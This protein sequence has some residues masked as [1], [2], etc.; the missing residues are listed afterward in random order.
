[1]LAV[2]I[3][4][5]KLTFFEATLQSLANQ[6]DQRFKVYIGND[7][8]PE[9]PLELLQNFQGKL[10]FQ[11]KKFDTNLGSISLVKHWERCVKM[12]DI[13]DWIM[14][15]GDDDFLSKNAISEFYNN[16]P[17]IN[18]NKIKVVRFASQIVSDDIEVTTK[19]FNHQEIESANNFFHRRS[20]GLTR[21]SLSEYFFEA[22]TL[23]INF[24]YNFPLAWYSDDL[25]ILECSDFG[26][27]FTINS[28]ITFV[29]I[30]SLSISG[31][32]NLKEKKQEATKLYFERLIN[33]YSNRFSK[34]NLQIIILRLE[35]FFYK[36]PNLKEYFEISKLHIKHIGFI[37]FLKFNVRIYLNRNFK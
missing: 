23:K 4:Y 9:N 6:T 13:E 37:G 3:P 21:S 15:L 26:D 22:K 2:V 34:A 28:A 1:M 30:S 36:N 16:L 8:S 35:S 33:L 18:S 24:F 20:N 25:A 27:I 12:I 14:I 19:T 11:Y 5:Y 17:K 10:D 31:S 32:E 29:R 7:A